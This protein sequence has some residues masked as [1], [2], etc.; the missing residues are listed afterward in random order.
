MAKP[1]QLV[2]SS[3]RDLKGARY[4]FAY[5]S[6]LN[7][8]Q[9]DRRCPNAT[10]VST[11]KLKNWTLVFRGVADI[12]PVD[13]ERGAYVVGALYEITD[14]CEA[15]LDRYEGFPHL[16]GKEK[17]EVEL[18]NGETVEAMVYTMNFGTPAPPNSV[19]YLTISNGFRDWEL[20]ESTLKNALAL[21]FRRDGLSDQRVALGSARPRTS[22][23]TTLIGSPELPRKKK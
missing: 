19:Y 18:P 1:N 20:P 9:F 22:R 8:M 17:I 21:A 23:S 6:N 7:R 2:I 12:V 5:G 13:E 10:P 11:G 16:Y 4:Y 15:A 3:S 14:A